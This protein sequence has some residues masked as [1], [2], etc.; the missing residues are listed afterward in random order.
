MCDLT[1]PRDATVGTVYSTL[2]YREACR[3]N[4]WLDRTALNLGLSVISADTGSYERCL[5]VNESPNNSILKVLDFLL[6]VC[7]KLH[8]LNYF[9]YVFTNTLKESIFNPLKPKRRREIIFLEGK[10][11]S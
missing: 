11:A 9:V 1:H 4:A 8:R 3:I 7:V 10:R 2:T 5:L 6:Y